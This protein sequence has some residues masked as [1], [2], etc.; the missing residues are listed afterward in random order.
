MQ[1]VQ[2]AQEG[3][4]KEL[5]SATKGLSQQRSIMTR[6][7]TASM[8][9]I[10]ESIGEEPSISD[11]LLGR[12][13]EIHDSNR[14]AYEVASTRSLK[15]QVD[16]MPDGPIEEGIDTRALTEVEDGVNTGSLMA[17]PQSKDIPDASSAYDIVL[18]F[19]NKDKAKYKAYWDV[20]GYSI[21]YGSKA[22]SPNQTITRD[23][24]LELARKDLT[25][26]KRLVN[27]VNKEYNYGWNKNQIEALTS[28][29]QNLGYDNLM[30]LTQDGT[31]STEDMGDWI[32]KYNKAKDK[33]G[34]LIELGGL[35]RRRQV[36][37]NLFKK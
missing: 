20:E 35:T 22:S 37:S 36:E 21:G 4:G 19:E 14:K 31:R 9:N 1:M 15:E 18:K 11:R 33:D 2:A 16:A 10:T 17:K 24:A 34:N 28:F 32:L 29:T 3:S 30:L 27:K 7:S 25:V 26:S 6:K 12:F 13:R 8:R 5:L 23:Q